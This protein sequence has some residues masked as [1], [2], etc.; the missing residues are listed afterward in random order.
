M[1]DMKYEL[2]LIILAVFV[3]SFSVTLVYAEPTIINYDD[4]PN[5]Q[6]AMEYDL[7]IDNSIFRDEKGRFNK[8]LHN[9]PI[10]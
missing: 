1:I 6:K 10:V 2:F 4:N 8:E 5:L 3:L 9:H 7:T